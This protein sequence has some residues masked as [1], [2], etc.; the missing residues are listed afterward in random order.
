MFFKNFSQAFIEKKR[1]LVATAA[2][3]FMTGQMALAAGGGGGLAQTK[4]FLENVHWA[5]H[6]FALVVTGIALTLLGYKIMFRGETIH[7][8]KNI[9]IGA[10][11]IV[12]A[13][14]LANMFFG[15]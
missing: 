10:A 6:G 13:T 14:E 5:L 11:L 1:E 3:C 9:L 8:C 4:K 12:G 7:E 15:K 2:L